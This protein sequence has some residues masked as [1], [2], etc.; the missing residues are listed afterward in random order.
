MALSSV[1]TAMLRLENFVKQQKYKRSIH[2]LGEKIEFDVFSKDFLLVIS[3]PDNGALLKTL[4]SI[5]LPSQSCHTFEFF[6]CIDEPQPA[7]LIQVVDF[8]C[9]MPKLSTSC[10]KPALTSLHI[11]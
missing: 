2:Y 9:L 10:I 8:A 4:N 5:F 7:D 11:L 6:L 3:I 1:G